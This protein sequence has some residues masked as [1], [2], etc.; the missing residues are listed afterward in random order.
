MINFIKA[1]KLTYE[2]LSGKFE[3]IYEVHINPIHI[4]S[5]TE[6]VEPGYKD[7]FKVETVNG[8]DYY[9]SEELAAV[10]TVPVKR[11]KA[12]Y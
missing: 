11:K 4:V 8:S 6:Y 10:I 12:T 1:K 5:I 9:Q 3:P 2:P 7:V